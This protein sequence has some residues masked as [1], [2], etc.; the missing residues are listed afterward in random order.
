VEPEPVIQA[1]AVAA[2]AE[3]VREAPAPRV[4]DALAPIMTLSAEEKIA[5]FT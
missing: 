4:H 1:P 5:L 2:A 3:K